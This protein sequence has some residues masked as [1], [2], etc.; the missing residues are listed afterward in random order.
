MNK[1]FYKYYPELTGSAVFI[2]YLSTLCP[3]ILGMDSGELAT[4]QATLS[5]P[6]P[7][8]YP[9]FTILGYIFLKFPLPF[10]TIVSLNIL[11][12]IWS[13][14]TVIVLIRTSKLLIENLREISS[15]KFGSSFYKARN[16]NLIITLASIFPGL[17][18]GFSLTFWLQSTHVEVH[19]LQMFLVSIVV[20]LL[21]KSYITKDSVDFSNVKKLHKNT[22]VWIFMV[23]G[24]GF[25]NHL[26]IIYSIPATILLFFINH[27]VSQRSIRN[28]VL[29]FFISFFVLAVFY[30]WMMYRASENIPFKYGDP[31]SLAGLYDHV[32]AKRYSTKMFSSVNSLK[33]QIIKFINFFQISPSE[34]KWGEFSFSLFLGITGLMF[35]FL[36]SKKLFLILLLIIVTT[37][38]ISLNYHIHD[39][40]EYYLS[41]FYIL[42]LVSSFSIVILWTSLPQNRITDMCVI[43][44]LVTLIIIQI[45][46]NFKLAD[47][48]NELEYERF[49]K[50]YIEAL[51]ENAVLYTDDWSNI[52][53]PA[54]YLQNIL[55]IR[56]DVK[57]FSPWRRICFSPYQSTNTKQFFENN[58]LIINENTFIYGSINKKNVELSD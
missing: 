35:L 47:K 42:C 31:S 24:L 4:A 10:E 33:Y 27:N 44:F 16:S 49:A 25:A 9:L 17:M 8:G 38:V 11:A 23:I 21:M 3:T 28:I 2:V 53:S 43:I 55:K 30:I 15:S 1:I 19:S 22:W 26:T 36:L 56:R 41:F 45:F 7:T 50:E 6:H 32:T 12:S 57:I 58:K 34:G 51:P 20:L 54:L 48:S 52:L 40:Q 37:I 13:T 18:L 29:L 46:G 14:L 39:I 5:I